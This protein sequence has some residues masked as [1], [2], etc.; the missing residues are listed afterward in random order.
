MLLNMIVRSVVGGALL[1]LV[2]FLPAGTLA[3]PQAWI[4][5]ALFMGCGVAIG[6]WLW[7]VNPDL[8]AERMKSPMSS[9]QALSDRIVMGAIMVV[10]WGWLVLAGLDAKRF[11][12]SAVPIWLEAIG[13]ILVLIAFLDG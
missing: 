1:G 8:L 2:L 4:F 9:D 6:I 13:A 10:F 12:W 3:W 11:G 5:M 7:K